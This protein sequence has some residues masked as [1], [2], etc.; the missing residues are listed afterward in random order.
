MKLFKFNYYVKLLL[1]GLLTITSFNSCQNEELISSD[2]IEVTEITTNN[3]Q[4]LN[5]S[6]RGGSGFLYSH[7]NCGGH[8]IERHVAKSDSYLRNRLNS[9][10][11]SAASTFNE[12]NQAGQVIY[13]AISRNS[14][15]VNSW[16]NGN[17]GSRLV[18]NYT[19]RRNIGRVLRRGASSTYNTSRFRVILERRNCSG[20]GY[21]ILTAYP[22]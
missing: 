6:A 19:H 15:R 13:N 5:V 17:G 7:E 11:I 14:S 10:S 18:L 9:S 21:R 8:T 16:L 3:Q 2:S 12:L 22:N 20:Y 4:E 1:L